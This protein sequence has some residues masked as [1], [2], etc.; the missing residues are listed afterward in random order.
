MGIMLQP[1]MWAAGLSFCGPSLATDEWLFIC[2]ANMFFIMHLLCETI[3]CMPWDVSGSSFSHLPF[4]SSVWSRWCVCVVTSAVDSD[5]Q[6]E[7]LACHTSGRASG[8]LLTSP[9]LI[10]DLAAQATHSSQ[11]W[12]KG[13]LGSW[14]GNFIHYSA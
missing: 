7:I 12:D 5:H 14:H 2:I 11:W 10:S 9:S 6:L 3:A 8:G 1:S 4:F 13:W